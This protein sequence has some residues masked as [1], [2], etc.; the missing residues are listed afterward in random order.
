MH[1][2]LKNTA[3]T[4]KSLECPSLPDMV[5]IYICI[6]KMKYK[7]TGKWNNWSIGFLEGNLKNFEW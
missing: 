1:S 6:T 7:E 3:M 2:S 4:F 5:T